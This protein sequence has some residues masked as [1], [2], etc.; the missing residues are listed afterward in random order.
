MYFCF[1]CLCYCVSVPGPKQYILYAHGT[2]QPISAES[3]IKHQLPTITK[4][5]KRL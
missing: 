5:M 1:A 4:Q 2:L 3:A